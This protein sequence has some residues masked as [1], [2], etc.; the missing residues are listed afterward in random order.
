MNQEELISKYK[1]QLDLLK[2]GPEIKEEQ[3]YDLYLEKIKGLRFSNDII[4]KSFTFIKQ[5]FFVNEWM[6][7]KF[8]L[9]FRNGYWYKYNPNIQPPLIPIQFNLCLLL[10]NNELFKIIKRTLYNFQKE[11]LINYFINMEIDSS[12]I[13]EIKL[14][15]EHLI[16]FKDLTIDSTTYLNIKTLLEYLFEL[17]N[18]CFV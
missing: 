1:Q 18:E 9:V 16:I 15:Q 17:D 10:T 4:I 8:M 14:I 12:K 5:H 13:E 7:N 2:F 3:D 6:Y 11:Y